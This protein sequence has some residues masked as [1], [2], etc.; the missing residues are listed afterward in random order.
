MTS[1]LRTAAFCLFAGTAATGC[2][3]AASLLVNGVEAKRLTWLIVGL[4]VAL[5]AGVWRGLRR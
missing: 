4:L 2:A 3:A 1:A 5:G